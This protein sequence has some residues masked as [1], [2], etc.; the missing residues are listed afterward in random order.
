[1]V[2]KKEM[3]FCKTVISNFPV[4][5]LLI[6]L[7][8]IINRGINPQLL[9]PNPSLCRAQL[10]LNS[11]FCTPKTPTV[12]GCY[13]PIKGYPFFLYISR[14]SHKKETPL[15]GPPFFFNPIPPM[16]CTFMQLPHCLP[17]GGKGK[18]ISPSG[19]LRAP[20]HIFIPNFP[21]TSWFDDCLPS[22][23]SEKHSSPTPIT[24]LPPTLIIQAESKFKFPGS[25]FS[26]QEVRAY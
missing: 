8:Q 21:S 25:D 2:L 13:T 22:S 5:L 18:N 17:S 12:T 16:C 7:Q 3:S 10:D 6:T 20:L 1:M 11:R 9:I 24:H 14:S 26:S 23:P 19:A 15:K 4:F